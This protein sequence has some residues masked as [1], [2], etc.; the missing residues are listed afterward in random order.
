[1]DSS[2]YS[3][4][5]CLEHIIQRNESA[6]NLTDFSAARV[7]KVEKT[8][9]SADEQKDERSLAF[10]TMLPRQRRVSTALFQEV[11]VKGKSFHS[12][13]LTL[14]LLYKDGLDTSHFSVIVPKKVSL[15]AVVRNALRRRLYPILRKFEARL[16]FPAVALIFVKTDISEISHEELT[17]EIRMLLSKVFNIEL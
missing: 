13:H 17:E 5:S 4:L 9:S 11:M 8:P 3:A 1:M 16:T 14:R 6:V 15:K 2:V 7:Q 10:N 12:S